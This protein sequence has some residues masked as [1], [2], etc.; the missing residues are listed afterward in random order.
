MSTALAH[1]AFGAAMT[2]LVIVTMVPTVPYPR[3]IV[4]F[5]GA[6]ALLP[7]V[8]RISPLFRAELEAFHHYSPWAD[9]FWLHGT[10]DRLDPYDSKRVTVAM[11]GMF[12]AVT[13]VAEWR[14]YR[15]RPH[16]DETA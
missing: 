2:T 14:G 1:V 10:L 16:S 15:L 13:I 5:G 4:A 8:Y 7:D 12:L 6:W 3:A 11:L 9:L